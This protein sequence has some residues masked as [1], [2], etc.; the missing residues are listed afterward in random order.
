MKLAIKW[1]GRINLNINLN[2][3]KSQRNLIFNICHIWKYLDLKLGHEVEEQTGLRSGTLFNAR[4]QFSVRE[5]RSIDHVLA[6]S[7]RECLV[8]REFS[9]VHA[10]APCT[11]P[12]VL[13]A[14]TTERDSTNGA[15]GG[16]TYLRPRTADRC[17]TPRGHSARSESTCVTRVNLHRAKYRPRQI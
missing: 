1:V 3:K 13:V 12:H 5:S 11:L 7:H 10:A 8:Q 14:H 2:H 6:E 9:V 17:R 16:V 15:C 4:Q